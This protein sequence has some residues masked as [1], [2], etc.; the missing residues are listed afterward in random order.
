MKRGKKPP[1]ENPPVEII[2]NEKGH[3]RF[4]HAIKNGER[5]L[6]DM[7]KECVVVGPGMAG[8][9]EVQYADGST[10]YAFPNMLTRLAQNI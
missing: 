3:F 5:F 7:G 1:K 9:P 10:N 2:R 8:M 6:D 4:E